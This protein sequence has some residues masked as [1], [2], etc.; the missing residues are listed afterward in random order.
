M[1]LLALYMGLHDSNVCV[2][3]DGRWRYRKFERLTNEHR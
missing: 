2:L 3:S 1:D